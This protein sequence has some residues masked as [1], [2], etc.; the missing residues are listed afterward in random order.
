VLVTAIEARPLR[1]LERVRVPLGPGITSVVGP[2][3]VT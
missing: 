2:N 3:G 1:S